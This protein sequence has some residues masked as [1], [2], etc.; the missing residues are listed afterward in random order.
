LVAIGLPVRPG[1]G[2][3]PDG[4]G[5]R[6]QHSLLDRIG[7]DPALDGAKLIAEPWDPG[8]GGYQLDRFP[9][10]WAEWNDRFRDTL[11]RFWR[12]HAGQSSDFARRIHGSADLFE[13]GG[14]NPTASINLVTSHD[15]FTLRDLVSY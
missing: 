8:P 15:G 10:V 2:A 4:K 9:T 3:R 5:F 1:D 12:G 7:S 14:R 6:K 13:P 11:R